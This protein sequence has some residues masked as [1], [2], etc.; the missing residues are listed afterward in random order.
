MF[1]DQTAITSTESS[2]G[3]SAGRKRIGCEG[4]ALRLPNVVSQKS[5][6]SSTRS[7]FHSYVPVLFLVQQT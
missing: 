4:F 3:K 1:G 2:C 5:P 6:G 7:A